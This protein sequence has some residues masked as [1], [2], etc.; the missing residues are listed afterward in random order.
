MFI[1]EN[2]EVTFEDE[3]RPPDRNVLHEMEL[4]LKLCAKIDRRRKNRFN[5]LDTLYE[6]MFVDLIYVES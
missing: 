2:G 6:K 3:A 5:A 1:S 4:L